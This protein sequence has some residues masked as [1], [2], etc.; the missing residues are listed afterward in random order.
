MT[1]DAYEPDKL[2]TR[3]YP[4]ARVGG[5]SRVNGDLEF[6]TRIN[7]LVDQDSRVLDFGAGRAWW[8]T[9]PFPEMS[10]RMRTFKGRVKEV[11]GTDVDPA[12]LDNPVLD[13]AHVVEL[14]APLPFADESFDL[15]Y[16]DYVLEHVNSD[17][18][19][20]VAADV[21]RVL[22]PG[23][24]FAARTPNKWGMTGLG[25]RAI[26]NRLHVKVLTRLQPERKAEDV[27]P[28][29]YEMNTRKQLR[30]QFAPHDV[31]V[32]GHS[33]EPAYFGRSVVAWRAAALLGRLTP[34]RL[35]PTLMVFVQ[36]TSGEGRG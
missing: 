34:P 15:V 29:R 18:A 6:Y 19:P 30:R 2:L 1:D 5:F 11:V 14:G 26:P 8:A 16:A 24:W 17:D 10:R 12:V 32:Y 21:M 22:K 31:H 9:E 36:K 3:M 13:S 7:A 35:S 20:D 23:G 25:A 27:F 4:E 28:V 33:S